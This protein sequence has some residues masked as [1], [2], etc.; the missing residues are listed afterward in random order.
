[1]VI[2]FMDS[3][4]TVCPFERSDI[5]MMETKALLKRYYRTSNAGKI[6]KPIERS[7]ERLFLFH[8]IT[9]HSSA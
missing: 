4:V 1:M 2:S 6:V 8:I 3:S 7:I 5:D 9:S